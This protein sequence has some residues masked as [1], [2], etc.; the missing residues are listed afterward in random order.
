MSS[1]PTTPIDHMPRSLFEFRRVMP[2]VEI[3]AHA[4]RSENYRQD[5]WW[6]WPGSASLLVSEY[7]KFLIARVVSLLDRGA[8]I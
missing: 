2:Q 7:N 1:L 5:D 8:Y 3:I 4:V 6:R